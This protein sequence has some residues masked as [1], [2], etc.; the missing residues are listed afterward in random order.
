MKR[1]QGIRAVRADAVRGPRIRSEQCS[2]VRPLVKFA[3]VKPMVLRAHP[4]PA[5]ASWVIVGGR[6]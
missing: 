1:L 5:G 3:L 6:F 4:E 2:M